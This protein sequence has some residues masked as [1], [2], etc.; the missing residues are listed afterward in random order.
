M[1]SSPSLPPSDTLEISVHDASEHLNNSSDAAA[2]TRVH[3][4]DC[5]EEDEYA[6]C[7]IE[8]ARLIPLSNFAAAMEQSLPEDK[9]HP[10]IVHCHHGMRSLQATHFL[11][12]KGYPNTWSLS[13]GID[14]WSKEIDTEVPRY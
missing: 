7:R 11:R 6:I 4:I 5:R 1:P 3:W 8:G 9:S 14:L 13:G 2:N 12:Q 10:I